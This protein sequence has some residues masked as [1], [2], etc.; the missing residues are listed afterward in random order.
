MLCGVDYLCRL[1]N[2]AL[3]RVVI[4]FFAS[5]VG[6]A[7]RSAAMDASAKKPTAEEWKCQSHTHSHKHSQAFSIMR[8]NWK[9]LSRVVRSK[10]L[11]R[12]LDK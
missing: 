5:A 3:L 6:Y 1:P 10:S 12:Y 7:V 4:Y 11:T 9:P 2:F 8:R